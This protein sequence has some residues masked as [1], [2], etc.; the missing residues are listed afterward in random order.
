M[1]N[2]ITCHFCT[3]ATDATKQFEKKIRDK[4]NLDKD[5]FLDD[6]NLLSLKINNFLLSNEDADIEEIVNNFLNDFSKIVDQHAPLRPQSR[7]ERKLN[8]KPWINNKIL[9]LIWTKN[10]MFR[11]CYEKNDSHL[12]E[13]YKKFAMN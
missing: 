8:S 6:V 7:K 9:K 1:I 12:I 5:S 11:K 10:S 3:L 4:R 2:Q 13:K